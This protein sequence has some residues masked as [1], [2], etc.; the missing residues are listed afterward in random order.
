MEV[1]D[2]YSVFHSTTA[3]YTFFSAAHRTF[4]K[5]YHILGHKENLNKYKKNEIIHYI[6]TD[7]N[8]IN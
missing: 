8:G 5:M 3:D 7:N 1:I 2:I 6:L 4:S